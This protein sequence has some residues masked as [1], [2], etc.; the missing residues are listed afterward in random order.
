MFRFI[1]LSLLAASSLAKKLKKPRSN[2]YW[3]SNPKGSPPKWIELQPSKVNVAGT[4][5]PRKLTENSQCKDKNFKLDLDDDNNPYLVI[6][7]DDYDPCEEYYSNT[8]WCGNWDT[9]DFISTEICCAC[10][11]GDRSGTCK[12]NQVSRLR[13]TT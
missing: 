7:T 9:T 11:G 5:A 3:V 10:Q 13:S 4:H 6:I 1:V 8:Q 2:G 12:H